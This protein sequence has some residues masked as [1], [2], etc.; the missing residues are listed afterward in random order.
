MTLNRITFG[1]AT[2]ALALT[3]TAAAPA[4][5]QDDDIPPMMVGDLYKMGGLIARDLANGISRTEAPDKNWRTPFCK[6]TGDQRGYCN[7]TWKSR[8]AKC[9]GRII[10]WLEEGDEPGDASFYIRNM[11]C[12]ARSR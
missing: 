8:T 3:L 6:M 1:I 9:S 2:V 11:R 12:R 4:T 7:A 10:I 5:A